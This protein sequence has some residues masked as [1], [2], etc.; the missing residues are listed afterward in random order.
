MI[1]C[2]NCK[3]LTKRGEPTGLIKKFRMWPNDEGELVKQ[4][5]ETKKGCMRC[6]I[7]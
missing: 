7:G 2:S 4:L 3:R 1:R 5:V 6:A